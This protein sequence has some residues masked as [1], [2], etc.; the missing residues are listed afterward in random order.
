MKLS[1]VGDWIQTQFNYS[2]LFDRRGRFYVV[3]INEA[4]DL[5]M[6][7]FHLWIH[8]NKCVCDAAYPVLRVW[9]CRC[10]QTCRKTAVTP[11]MRPITKCHLKGCRWSARLVPTAALAPT[12][13]RSHSA[14]LPRTHSSLSFDTVHISFAISY[15]S[16]RMAAW[17][18]L[19]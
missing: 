3:N 4:V 16:K 11:V 13:N 1:A 19:D 15:T 7:Q 17:A 10:T 8:F 14:K 9:W 12:C 18:P 5:C 2:R 6:I